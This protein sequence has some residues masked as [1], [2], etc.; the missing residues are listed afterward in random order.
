MSEIDSIIDE[1]V[2]GP[3]DWSKDFVAESYGRPHGHHAASTSV[4]IGYIDID[5][6]IV[7]AFANAFKKV[8]A[9]VKDIATTLSDWDWVWEILAEEQRSDNRALLARHRQRR[10]K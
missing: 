2:N 6:E 8:S 7:D 4:G 5:P 1:L 10:H 3:S 9:V